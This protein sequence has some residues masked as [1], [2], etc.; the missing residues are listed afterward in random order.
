MDNSFSEIDMSLSLED[1][2]K[3]LWNISDTLYNIY[4]KDE[5]KLYLSLDKEY[6]L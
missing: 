2:K 6:K 5:K 4:I 1:T 3:L